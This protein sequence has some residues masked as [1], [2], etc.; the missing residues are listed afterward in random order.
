MLLG[1]P[2]DTRGEEGNVLDKLTVESFTGLVGDTFRASG[3]GG[4]TH[5]LRLVEATDH[6][7][8]FGRFMREESRAPF[9][10]IFLGPEEPVLPQAIRRLEHSSLGELEIFLV[11]IGRGADGVRYEAVFN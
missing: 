5:D 8:R 7:D 9:S 3:D 11:P 10:L 6:E 1:P 4:V 2:A